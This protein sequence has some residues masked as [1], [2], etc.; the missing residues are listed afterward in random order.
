MVRDGAEWKE[1]AGPGASI[2]LLLLAPHVLGV[3]LPS[4]QE[5]STLIQKNHGKSLFKIHIP[6]ALSPD[7]LLQSDLAL[8]PKNQYFNKFLRD[9]HDRKHSFENFYFLQSQ[10][11]SSAFIY[12]FFCSYRD[13]MDLYICFLMKEFPFRMLAVEPSKITGNILRADVSSSHW[14]RDLGQTQLA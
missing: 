9:S 3:G 8:G 12:L 11:R 14:G 13:S 10:F 2:S 7:I 4:E 5:F 1:R 6:W